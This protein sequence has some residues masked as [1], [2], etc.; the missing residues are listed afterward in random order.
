M[1]IHHAGPGE[2]IDIRPLGTALAN[3]KTH[4]LV[5]TD[6]LEIIRL[7]LPAGKEIPSH[8]APGRLIVQCLEG[9][10]MFSAMGSDLDLQ[11]GHLLHLPANEPHSLR[12]VEASSLLLTILRLSDRRRS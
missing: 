11:T 5:K 7:V 12:A 10:V 3:E 1:A 6:D 4:A 9:R 8:R 2:L